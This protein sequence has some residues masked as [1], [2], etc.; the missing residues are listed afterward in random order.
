MSKVLYIVSGRSFVTGHLGRKIAEVIKC[1]S[2]NIVSLDVI[3]GGDNQSKNTNS[4]YGAQDHFDKKYRQINWLTPVITSLSELKDILHDISF[5]FKIKKK[6][7]TSNHDLIWERSSRLHI[8]GLL[9]ARKNKIPYVLEWK[10]NLVNYKFSIFKPLA[11]LVERLKVN[12]A[13]FIVVESEVLKYQIIELGIQPEKI[14]VAYNAVDSEEFFLENK[15]E[16]YRKMFNV[17]S[18]DVLVGYLGSYAFYHSPALLI[19]AAEIIKKH[20]GEINKNIRFLMVGNGKHYNETL[21]LAKNLNLYNVTVFFVDGVKKEDVPEVLSELDIAV[22]PGSTDI[23]C[24]IKIFEYM[25]AKKAVLLPDYQCN[26][27]IVEDNFDGQMFIPLDAN[28]LANKIMKL[29]NDD[30]L[31]EKI[32]LNAQNKVIESF[33]WENTWGKVMSNI[34]KEIKR[35]L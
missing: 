17:Q 34:L 24:P 26:K 12:Y 16:S 15:G 30:F 23:I 13:N 28:D 11:L 1:W 33:T 31:R 18:D 22:L 35:E 29:T 3:S 14:Y 10:D 6:F 32:G 21:N 19:E 2:N 4:V 25:A 20:S 8:S 5:Y 9:Y 7:S 27:E